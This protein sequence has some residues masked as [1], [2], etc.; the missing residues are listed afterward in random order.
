M[1]MASISAKNFWT[2]KNNIMEERRKKE[3]LFLLGVAMGAA[4][5]YYINSE[6]GRR[7]RRQATASI[8]DFGVEV[9]TKAKDQFGHLSHDVSEVVEQG[10]EYI[11]DLRTRMGKA[12]SETAK[13]TKRELDKARKRIR[14]GVRRLEEVIETEM[15]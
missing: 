13:M 11:N 7:V 12:G 15:S 4:A 6:N 9:K 3:L 8:N 5:G 2:I 10:K 14:K 1:S